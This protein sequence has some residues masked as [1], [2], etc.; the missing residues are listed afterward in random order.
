MC[1]L[2]K[3]IV[4]VLLI[5]ELKLISELFTCI[6]ALV[7]GLHFYAVFLS[8][9]K[10]KNDFYYVLYISHYLTSTT[11][12]TQPVSWAREKLQQPE[13]TKRSF[14]IVLNTYALV[15]THQSTT[16]QQY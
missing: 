10:I 9:I 12:S 6:L 15:T 11:T 3:L 2:D 4:A 7:M 5:S 14:H 8:D 13:Q 16:S 1:F